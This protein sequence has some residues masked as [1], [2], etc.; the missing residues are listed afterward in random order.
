MV[1]SSLM[2][3]GEPT[4]EREAAA[5][6]NLNRMV[7][8]SLTN[9]SVEPCGVVKPESTHPPL[10]RLPATTTRAQPAFVVSM[11]VSAHT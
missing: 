9:C 2:P 6:N 4:M 5:L 3:H 7:P 8:Q 1:S 10:M 11:Q